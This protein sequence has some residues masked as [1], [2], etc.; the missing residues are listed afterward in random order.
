MLFHQSWWHCSILD[1]SVH[2]QMNRVHTPPSR[3]STG[4]NS[5][6]STLR[7]HNLGWSHMIFS[8]FLLLSPSLHQFIGASKE[9]FSAAAKQPGR[10]SFF[11]I[12][13]HLFI[14]SI[15]KFHRTFSF[16]MCRVWMWAETGSWS[17]SSFRLINSVPASSRRYDQINPFLFSDDILK[18]TVWWK[19]KVQPCAGRIGSCPRNPWK[20]ITIYS[21]QL[22]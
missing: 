16:L 14:V 10:S 11:K 13:I 6:S 5:T 9:G 15:T 17:F 2:P 1:S 22:S 21:P 8:W 12:Y 7:T 19:R 20:C 4:T 3:V 18:G